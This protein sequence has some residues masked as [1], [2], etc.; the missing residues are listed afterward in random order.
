MSKRGN[1]SQQGNQN[2]KQRF[3]THHI[4]KS[5]KT[6][7]DHESKFLKDRAESV[8]M[9]PHSKLVDYGY[10]NFKEYFFPSI[11]PNVDKG[12]ILDDSRGRGA[13]ND[14]D[15]SDF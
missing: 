6:K 2:Q 7:I 4:R 12:T 9:T 5:L 14:P 15:W 1:R 10:A 3:D 8:C 11:C 13:R